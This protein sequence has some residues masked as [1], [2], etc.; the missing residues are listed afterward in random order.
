[1]PPILPLRYLG[2][3]WYRALAQLRS[4][5]ARAYL[6]YVWW[7]LEPLL[8]LVVFY[9]VFALVLNRGDENYVRVLLVGLVVFKWLDASV[10]ASM[11]V[12]QQNSGLIDRVYIPKIVLPLIWVTSNGVKFFLVFT[13]LLIA[14]PLLGGPPGVSWLFIPVLVGIQLLLVTSAS[15]FA[16]AITPFIPDIRLIFDKVMTLLFFM[17]GIFYTRESIPEEVQSYFMIN[18]VFALIDC[19][20]SVLINS[21]LPMVGPLL[22]VTGL[23]LVL[24]FVSAWLLNR[25]DRVY[26]R[27][28]Y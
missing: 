11:D 6:G 4:E 5:S 8:Y 23:S 20:R 25:F 21:E 14:S 7:I 27:L 12:I 16:A 13:L 10:R 22:Y 24:L 1:M 9:V 15:C 19:Y 17:S 26:P 28:I 2:F 18:P 3:I